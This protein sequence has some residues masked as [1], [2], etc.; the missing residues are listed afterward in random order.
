MAFRKSVVGLVWVAGVAG[1]A[2]PQPQRRAFNHSTNAFLQLVMVSA[3]LSEPLG[4][5][6]LQPAP[7]GARRPSA[8]NRTPPLAQ[9]KR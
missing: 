3:Y 4:G 2:Q 5:T 9:R 1:G 7:G 6:I 8:S